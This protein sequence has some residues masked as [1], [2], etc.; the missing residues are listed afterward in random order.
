MKEMMSPSGMTIP[1]A[2]GEY[3]WKPSLYSA[4]VS[5][6]KNEVLGFC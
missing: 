5:L 4:R 2:N 6:E 3:H 1:T